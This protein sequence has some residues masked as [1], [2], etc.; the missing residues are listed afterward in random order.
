[1]G[2][3]PDHQNSNVVPIPFRIIEVRYLTG[4]FEGEFAASLQVRTTDGLH[5]AEFPLNPDQTCERT[6]AANALRSLATSIARDPLDPQ[7]L[8]VEEPDCLGVLNAAWIA[9]A[10]E[11]AAGASAVSMPVEIFEELLAAARNGLRPRL[12]TQR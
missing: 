3:M 2:S 6:V 5:A 8:D 12:A 10:E 4:E 9:E 7:R 11:R 1:M